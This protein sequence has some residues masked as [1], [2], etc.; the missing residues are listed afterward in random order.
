MTGKPAAPVIA[1][2]AAIGVWRFSGTRSRARSSRN[3]PGRI[4]VRMER[5]LMPG[6]KTPKPPGSQ[7][8]AWPGCQRRT[9][10]FQAM[11]TE[12]TARSASQALAGATAGA[13][14]ECQV[15][16]RPAP[17]AR[18]ASSIRSSSPSV[19][20]GGFSSRTSRP[21]SSA[22][23][24][25]RGARLRRHAER[26]GGRRAVGEEAVDVG[27]VR[28]AV[29]ALVAR[30]RGDELEVGVGLDRRDVLVAGDLADADQG[31]GDRAGHQCD[32]RPT[33]WPRL[34]LR[35]SRS[36][37]VSAPPTWSW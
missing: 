16:K 14:R 28:H 11:W 22:C 5:A 29:E 35:K 34:P 3:G 19:A 30:H 21:A 12:R 6:S 13:K 8:Q 33:A 9:S 37:P 20:A 26:H 2:S 15:A 17:L 18:A 25:H 23:D 7:I 1:R 4:S 10:S 27:E 36:A 31:D 24:R 32:S